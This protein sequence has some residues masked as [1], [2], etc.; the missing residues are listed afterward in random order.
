MGHISNESLE[1][2]TLCQVYKIYSQYKNKRNNLV[3][4]RRN[5]RV[6]R[7]DW[8]NDWLDYLALREDYIR[9]NKKRLT[10]YDLGLR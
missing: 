1:D 6:L 3:W 5:K 9:N 2:P 8:F 10:E 4:D 7:V